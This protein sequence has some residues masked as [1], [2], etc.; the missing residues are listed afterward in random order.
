MKKLTFITTLLFVCNLLMAQL[1]TGDFIKLSSF[2]DAK[3]SYT[4]EV[5]KVNGTSFICKFLHSQ[6]QYTFINFAA[7]PNSTYNFTAQVKASQGAYK[8]GDV[9]VFNVNRPDNNTL[10]LANFDSYMNNDQYVYDTHIRIVVRFADGKKY[11]AGGR[12]TADNK[13]NLTF[14]HSKAEYTVDLATMKVTYSNGG[15][16]LGSKVVMYAAKW[17]S[18]ATIKH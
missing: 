16:L 2:K 15:Y 6:S 8:A 10:T 9:A 3:V 7:Q 11:L 13:L 18:H 1:K 17:V 5:T 14:F 12:K 4:A